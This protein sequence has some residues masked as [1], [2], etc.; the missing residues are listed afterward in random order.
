MATTTVWAGEVAAETAKSAASAQPAA[1][2]L[3]ASLQAAMA[4]YQLPAM[5]A[6]LIRKGLV[7]ELAVLGRRA[8][9][10]ADPVQID[11][12]WHL[13]S[14]GKAMTAV[15]VARLVERGLLSWEAPLSQLLPE[16]AAE[17]QAGY[18]EAT[19]RDLFAH[20]SGLQPNID[21]SWEAAFQKD[22]RSLHEQRLA[23]ARLA[24]AQAPAFARGSADGYSNNGVLIAGLVAERA[25][26]LPYE[27]LMR[28]E[29]FEPLGLA[30]AG[31]GATHRGQPLGHKAGAPVEGALADNPAVLAPAGGIHMSLQD[32]A[33]FAIDQMAGEQ[34]R[35]RLLK[36]ESYRLLHQP[37][38]EGG[39]FA[40]GWRVQSSMAGVNARHLA[41]TGSNERWFALIA[42]RPDSEDAVL[43]SC[44]AGEDM[45]ADKAVREVA[46][47]LLKGMAP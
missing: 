11:D 15:M 8:S 18:R 10:S 29:V 14:N 5:G 37:A 1:P 46:V 19:L 4:E 44:N 6:V 43:V 27:T 28:G 40:L 26:G 13:G 31:F 45:K 32:W 2:S 33:R 47:R 21:E 9:G 25:S 12:V 36:A 38:R 16:L 22:T 24:L 30:S 3:D 17:M 41:H 39:K 42:M 35:G 23:F 7:S 20:Q 34:G